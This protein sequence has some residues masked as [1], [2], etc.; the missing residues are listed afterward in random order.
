MA[1]DTLGR[2][3]EQEAGDAPATSSAHDHQVIVPGSSFSQN[4][5]G[6]VPFACPEPR[7]GRA[8]QE[9][10]HLLQGPL[11][12]VRPTTIKSGRNDTSSMKTAF[13]PWFPNT[14]VG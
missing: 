13:P 10:P 5:F 14:R 6:G 7:L 1:S 3:A 12:K 8:S 4:L 9:T 11:D 2:G